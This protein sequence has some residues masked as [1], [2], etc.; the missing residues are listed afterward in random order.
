VT[1]WQHVLE[2]FGVVFLV[3]WGLIALVA[4]AMSIQNPEAWPEDPRRKDPR[5]IDWPKAR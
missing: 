3:Q 5:V 2:A 1:F 4:L